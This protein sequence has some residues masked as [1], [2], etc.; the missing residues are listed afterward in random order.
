MYMLTSHH[1]SGPLYFVTLKEAEAEAE[2]LTNGY[3]EGTI[4]NNDPKPSIF[5][6]MPLKQYEV[7]SGKMAWK[8]L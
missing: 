7:V 3:L 5:K 2:R 4:S 1:Y 6:I 8:A